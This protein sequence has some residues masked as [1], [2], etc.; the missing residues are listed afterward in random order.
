M[1]LL[2]IGNNKKLSKSVG[3]FNL[4]AQA[5]CPGK[6]PECTKICYA[7]KAERMYRSAHE[8]R[9]RNLLAAE[10]PDFPAMITTE[11]ALWKLGRIRVHESGDFYCQ[12]YLDKWITIATLNPAVTFLAFTKSFHLDFS[13]AP[14]NLVL[15]YSL[16]TSTDPATLPKELRHT[17]VTLQKGV[18]MAP[19]R[20]VCIPVGKDAALVRSKEHYHYCGD[21]CKYCW[22]NTGDVAWIKH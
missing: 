8:M 21:S 6:T 15:F 11:I 18:M 4:P 19:G 14:V 12:G 1:S 22:D 5:T 2:S 3:V 16:D 17:A 9:Q 20:H 13:K 7:M 10:L